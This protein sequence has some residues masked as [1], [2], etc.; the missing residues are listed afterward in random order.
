MDWFLEI[1]EVEKLTKVNFVVLA[2]GEDVINEWLDAF[3][4]LYQMRWELGGSLWVALAFVE[5]ELGL[6]LVHVEETLKVTQCIISLFFGNIDSSH[7]SFASNN[8]ASVIQQRFS[9]LIFAMVLL[10]D[11]I[12]YN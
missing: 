2:S 8:A 9:R 10:A 7:S 5:L 4:C 11:V 1:H 12:T 3:Q 6:V